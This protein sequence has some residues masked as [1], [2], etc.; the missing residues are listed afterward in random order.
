MTEHNAS[1]YASER[2]KHRIRRVIAINMF[3]G[4]PLFC[5][6]AYCIAPTRFD[7]FVIAIPLAAGW[8]G[9]AWAAV[10]WVGQFRCPRCRRRYGSLGSRGVWVNWTRG[11]FEDIC[12]NCRLLKAADPNVDE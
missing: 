6:A 3:C 9:L 10:W 1:K 8:F 2:A 12:P 4:F 7:L 11:L 5:V